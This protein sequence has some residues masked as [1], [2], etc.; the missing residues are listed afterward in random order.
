MA[1]S[2]Q[3][4]ARHEVDVSD[5][6]TALLCIPGEP[7]GMACDVDKTF[8]A[9]EAFTWRDQS[10]IGDIRPAPP[11]P[12]A[13]PSINGTDQVGTPPVGTLGTPT[14]WAWTTAQGESAKTVP[15]TVRQ[16]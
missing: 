6:D 15:T 3:H 7:I 16:L 9:T 2:A 10:K 12:A 13:L 14:H 1:T 8:N 4:L 11:P 5:G